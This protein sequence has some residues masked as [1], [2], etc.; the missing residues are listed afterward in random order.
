[1]EGQQSQTGY[2]GKLL[3]PSELE[4]YWAACTFFILFFFFKLLTIPNFSFI[5]LFGTG[6]ITYLMPEEK[7]EY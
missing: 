1:M 7:W 3:K 6:L 2:S 5:S 4:Q